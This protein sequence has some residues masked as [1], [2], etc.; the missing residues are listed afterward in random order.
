[1]WGYSGPMERHRAL[2]WALLLASCAAGC[3]EKKSSPVAPAPTASARPARLPDD[4]DA[5]EAVRLIAG[6]YQPVAS[7]HSAVE[8]ARDC[9]QKN[10]GFDG[11]NNCINRASQ[12]A[13]N[14]AQQVPTIASAT[15]PCAI[16]IEK[17][18]RELLSVAPRYLA[19]L[20]QA[21]RSRQGEL[22]LALTS[23]PLGQYCTEKASSTRACS[24]LPHDPTVA[25][26]PYKAASLAVVQQLAC[27]PQL[28]QCGDPSAP[29]GVE[30]VVERLG[31]A[32][33]PERNK[34]DG[35]PASLLR[36]RASQRSL[37]PLRR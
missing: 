29:C 7:V 23:K 4:T 6:L 30:D 22:A 21:V 27:A 11:L 34:I 15:T 1:M 3:D 19:E 17:A 8:R 25:D 33:Q 32:H 20:L 28:F 37:P 24:W 16:A 35:S 13:Q 14:V 12:H 26:S 9:I 10:V 31:L 2:C 5:D 18:E 36:V